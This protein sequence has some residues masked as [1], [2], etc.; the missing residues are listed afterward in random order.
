MSAK[1]EGIVY[2]NLQGW[3]ADMQESLHEVFSMMLGMKVVPSDAASLPGFRAELTAIVGLA[4]SLCGLFV[5]RCS[6]ST[7]SQL[8]EKMLGTNVCEDQVLDA[9]GELCNM[10]AG[11]FKSRIPDIG[12]TCMLSV[13]TTIVGEDHIIHTAGCFNRFEFFFQCDDQPLQVILH[14]DC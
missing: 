3:T 2:R 9:L 4:G 12:A 14:V 6:T 8:A 10:L 1:T 5:I 11:G 13:P 7:G